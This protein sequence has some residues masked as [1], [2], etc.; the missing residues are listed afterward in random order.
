MRLDAATCVLTGATGGIGGRSRRRL[1][2]PARSSCS[3]PATR[4]SSTALAAALPAGSVAGCHAGDLNEPATQDAVAALGI[5]AG[6]NVLVNLAGANRFGLLERQDQNEIRAL[7]ETNLDRP[8]TLTRQLLPHLLGLPAAMVVNVGS[9]FGA[10]G[11][12]GYAL[13]CASKFGLRGF[14][15]AL[16]R[17]LAD[18]PV[19]VV[20][21]APRA[22]RTAM[23]SAAATALNAELGNREDAPEQVA[24][25]IVKA[26]TRQ[27]R[28][29]G[30]G[31]PEQLFARI[32]QLAARRDGPRPRRTA[33]H[34][35]SSS[36]YATER[37]RR[38]S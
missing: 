8:V 29:T 30:L 1:R 10:I 26:M 23:N 15:E 6:A 14:S 34:H 36:R 18:G 13:Y 11:Y 12:P 2:R 5:R 35:Q 24:H 19:R 4:C 28:R 37:N 3:R 31:W 38:N 20:Y 17:E 25:A 21:V 32:N 7:L 9:T 33:H 16:A 22:V 27:A